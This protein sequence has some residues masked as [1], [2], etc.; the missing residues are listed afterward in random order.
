DLKILERMPVTFK[1][2]CS[3]E[4]IENALIGL[5]RQE[6][7]SMINEDHGAEAS[8]HFCNE[9]YHFSEDDLRALIEDKQD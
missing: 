3:K 8:C 4:K 2:Q 6:I 7:E 5:G 9:M 1:C